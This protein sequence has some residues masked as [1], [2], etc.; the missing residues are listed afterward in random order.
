MCTPTAWCSNFVRCLS[1]ICLCLTGISNWNFSY[2]WVF[3]SPTMI[4]YIPDGFNSWWPAPYGKPARQ[5][6]TLATCGQY[7]VNMGIGLSRFIPR[8]LH[9]TCTYRTGEHRYV[10]SAFSHRAVLDV[11]TFWGFPS[12]MHNRFTSNHES[13]A[14]L[15]VFNWV[16]S[17]QHTLSSVVSTLRKC[18]SHALLM[19]ICIWL[20]V[21]T[22]YD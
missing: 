4:V 8:Y 13:W 5:I 14:E 11:H 16:L 12:Y 9:H 7:R 10:N 6:A 18:C 21:R 15:L 3:P 19:W 22:L 1:L 17:V 2:I 20:N